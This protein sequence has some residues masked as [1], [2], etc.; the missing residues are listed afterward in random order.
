[1]TRRTTLILAAVLGAAVAVGVLGVGGAGVA[2]AMVQEESAALRA[3]GQV[4]EQTDGY[5]GVVG[6]AP[7][8]IRAQVDAVN[9]K[10]RAFYTQ[11]AAKRNAKIEEV[12]AAAACRIFAS[13]I[14]PGQYYR[15]SDGSWQ[16]R[17]GSAPVPRPAY[18]G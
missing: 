1:M 18:C 8:P 15:G 4:G 11:I 6:A 2:Q 12:A 14:E 5:L 10:R 3:T 13:R 17:E 7:A 9:I 16:Q